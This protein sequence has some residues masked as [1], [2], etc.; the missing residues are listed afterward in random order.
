LKQDERKQAIL[1]LLCRRRHDKIGNLAFE[2]NVSEK[3]IRNDIRELSKSYPIF[4]L[5]GKSYGGVYIDDNFRYG[6]FYLNNGQM[7]FLKKLLD[8][9]NKEDRKTIVSVLSKYFKL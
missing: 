3:T 9:I 2:L 5:K 1:E 4:T 7:G 6:T 8:D